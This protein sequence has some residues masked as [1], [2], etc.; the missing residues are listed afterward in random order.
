MTGVSAFSTGV[1]I[2]GK[3][4]DAATEALTAGVPAAPL[5]PVRRPDELPRSPEQ[6]PAAD[7]KNPAPALTAEQAQYNRPTYFGAADVTGKPVDDTA[8]ARR[9]A[10]ATTPVSE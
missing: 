1:A 10:T 7:V 6:A 5:L 8:A 2:E 9:S 4:S 3:L